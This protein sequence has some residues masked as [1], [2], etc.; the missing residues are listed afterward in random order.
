MTFQFE[1]CW[2][3]LLNVK[4]CS[5]KDKRRDKTLGKFCRDSV[6]L[7]G[8]PERVGSSRINMHPCLTKLILLESFNKVKF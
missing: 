3:V 8:K 5:R 4:C 7:P 1:E 2:S 6:R